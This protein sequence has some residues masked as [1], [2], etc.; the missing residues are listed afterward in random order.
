MGTK[1]PD[2]V[3]GGGGTNPV[4]KKGKANGDL[5]AEE[6]KTADAAAQKAGYRHTDCAGIY[7]DEANK[8]HYKFNTATGKLE[9]FDA[10]QVWADGSYSYRYKGDERAQG[11]VRNV[12]D[13]NGNKI[14]Q[15]WTRKSDGA[16]ILNEYK[17][18]K[19]VSCTETYTD[20]SSSV[21]LDYDSN[22]E[23]T[24]RI[25]RD[26]DGNII[27]II[28][29]ENKKDGSYKA[30]EVD[31]QGKPIGEPTYY[32]KDDNEMPKEEYEKR[33]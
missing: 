15:E 12:Y 18:G 26:K 8:Q 9:K 31:A 29:F 16:K 10:H 22:Q 17:D 6:K 7:Y 14:Q 32:D 13:K 21:Y 23:P 24:K 1:H 30:Q 27:S 3:A 33:Q 11:D 20:G 2:L 4:A 25:N 19:R 5:T 28:T